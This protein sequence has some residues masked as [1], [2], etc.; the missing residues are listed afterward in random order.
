MKNKAIILV[1]VRLKSKRLK[2]KALLNL[3]DKPLI[4]QLTERLKKSKLSSE[5]VWCTSK[6]KDDDRL[7]IL[8]KKTNVKIY[9][10]DAKDV[11]KRFIFAAK[12]FKAKNIV[13]VTGDNPLTDPQVIDFMIKSH[14]QKK[15]DYTSCNSI[16]FGTRSEV[17]SFKI[18]KKCHSMLADPNSSEYMTWMLNRPKYFK[19]NDLT[20]P[21]PKINRPEISLTVDYLQDYKNVN[22]IYNYFRGKIPSLQ[23]I[24]GWLDKNKKL[25]KKLKKKRIVKKPKNINVKFNRVYET[26]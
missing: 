3:F 13:R 1:A 12:K 14:V 23:K 26:K 19:T 4:I 6:N 8:A 5:I 18:L 7:E 2:N 17:V 20:Y 11:M 16:P 24:I 10:G 15:K 9:R 25:L 21:N 22:E